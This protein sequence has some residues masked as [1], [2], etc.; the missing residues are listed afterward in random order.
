MRARELGRQ[1]EDLRGR[2]VE[3]RLLALRKLVAIPEHQA[4]E[5]QLPGA[6]VAQGGEGETGG[7]EEAPRRRSTVTRRRR[8]RRG[9]R[10]VRRWRR[11]TC[12]GQRRCRSG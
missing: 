7:E 12:E 3:Q 1:I 10:A 9:V 8:T 5:D 11:P 6:A 4:R 2:V